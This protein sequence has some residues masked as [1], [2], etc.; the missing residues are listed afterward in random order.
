MTT[1]MQQTPSDTSLARR[2]PITRSVPVGRRFLLGDRR[3]T[4]LTVLGVAASLLLVLVLGGIFAGAVD[5]VT[6]YIRTSPAE[7]FVSQTGCAPCTCPPPHSQTTPQPGQPR[8]RRRLG[9]AGR[10]RG[11][12]G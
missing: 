9:R 2:M 3:R 12:P 4:A 10:R 1:T 7:V 11:D 6:H 5:R 8:C